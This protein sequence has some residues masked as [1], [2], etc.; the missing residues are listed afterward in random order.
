MANDDL[1]DVALDLE[2]VE[3]E[4]PGGDSKDHPADETD[5]VETPEAETEETPARA[6]DDEDA[7]YGAKVR[8]RID[9]EVWR[10]KS[11][12]EEANRLKAELA[13]LRA[14]VESIKSRH[15][16]AEA[17]AT[18]GQWREQM[19]AA[20]KRLREAKE[21][22]DIDAELKAADEYADARDRLR[23]AEA[24]RQQPQQQSTSRPEPAATNLPAGT[25]AWLSR[26]GWFQS[27]DNPRAARL[28]VEL[29]AELQ[30]DGYSPHDPEMYAELNRRLKA[31]MPKIA[32]LLGEVVAR[33]PGPPTGASSADGNSPA[34]AKKRKLS[35]ADLA[36]MQEFGLNPNSVED[37]K[38]WLR[39]HQ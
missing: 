37:R 11:A 13:A 20:Q 30:A 19:L 12:E 32:P 5:E 16:A 31:A 25:R 38:V 9:K 4:S 34:P 35:T 2:D 27:G 15:S 23:S 6:A 24:A 26:N 36:E 17:Q 3:D 1:D 14:D 10:R 22:G 33:K 18:E 8:K 39:A 28:A 21:A 7:S 29:D